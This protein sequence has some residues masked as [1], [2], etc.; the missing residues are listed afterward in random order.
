MVGRI[1][2]LIAVTLEAIDFHCRVMVTTAAEMF[3]TPKCRVGSLRRFRNMTVN[4]F[5]ETVLLGPYAFTQGFIAVKLQVFHVVFPHVRDRSYAAILFG[6]LGLGFW[7]VWRWY[8]TRVEGQG[9]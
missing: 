2:G 1:G 7:Y 4:A 6:G 5:L 8:I 3:F 9:Q